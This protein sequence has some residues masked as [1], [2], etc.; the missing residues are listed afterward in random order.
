MKRISNVTINLFLFFVLSLAAPVRGACI[1]VYMIGDSTMA[2]KEKEKFPETGWGQAFTELF[3]DSV[4]VD[5]RALDGRS[6]KSFI[7]EGR[8]E[9]IFQSLKKGDYVI[10]QFGH[11]DEKV[12]TARG[13]TIYDYKQNLKRFVTDTQAKGA[14]PILLTPVTRR[15][16]S[17]GKIVDTHGAYSKAVREVAEEEKVYFIDA[18]SLTEKILLDF[19]EKAS[20]EL[21][22][23]VMPGQYTYYPDGKA[24]NTHFSVKGARIIAEA[25]ASEIKQMNLSLSK[26][27]K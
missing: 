4:R 7:E 9:A 19:G 6:S 8:W 10:I 3:I 16:F 15:T 1:V 5:N 2:N 23:W 26:L 20:K 22:L 21:F 25:I 13:T 17:E 11:N 14:I 27:F 18:Y 24:D 12:D